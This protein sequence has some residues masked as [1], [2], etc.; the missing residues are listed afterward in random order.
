MLGIWWRWRQPP[1]KVLGATH[2]LFLKSRRQS[3]PPYKLGFKAGGQ[4]VALG[5]ARRKMLVVLA[6]PAGHLVA[7]V[8]GI[9]ITAVI[10]IMAFPVSMAVIVVIVAIL[11]IVTV[12]VL[13]G[14]R[15]WGR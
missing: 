15:Q 13:L 6:V 7:V 11:F 3:A 4:A 1:L 10:L 14:D 5:Q 9:R 12:T 2:N 8:I